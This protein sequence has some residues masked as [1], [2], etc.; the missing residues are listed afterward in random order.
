MRTPPHHNNVNAQRHI[1]TTA[2]TPFSKDV[3]PG[4]RFSLGCPDAHKTHM[5]ARLRVQH[6]QSAS[7]NKN[8]LLTS[9]SALQKGLV[10]SCRSAGDSVT[11]LSGIFISAQGCLSVRVPSC[12]ENRFVSMALE[13]RG[14]TCPYGGDVQGTRWMPN[15]KGTECTATSST[16]CFASPCQIPPFGARKR[17]RVAT[18]SISASPYLHQATD[19]RTIFLHQSSPGASNFCMTTLCRRHARRCI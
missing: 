1:C 15:D 10:P 11:F 2:P 18:F 16:L 3:T 7:T 14:K 5:Q 4:A 9:R 8:P 17:R 19:A 12:L 6:M 13:T